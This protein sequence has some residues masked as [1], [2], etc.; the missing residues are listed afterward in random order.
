MRAGAAYGSPAEIPNNGAV[1]WAELVD[2]DGNGTPDT[3]LH[4]AMQTAESVRNNPT[5]T[6]AQLD[7]QRRIIQRI[8]DTI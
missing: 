2:T 6:P 5:A 4:Q 8:N 1:E 7:A 3:A